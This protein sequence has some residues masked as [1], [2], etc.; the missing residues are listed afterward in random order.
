[1]KFAFFN[2]TKREMNIHVASRI[3]GVVY[4][5]DVI[6]PHTIKEFTLPEGTVPLVKLWDYNETGMTILVTTGVGEKNA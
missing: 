2:D 5:G 4:E 3:G 6:N 1:M